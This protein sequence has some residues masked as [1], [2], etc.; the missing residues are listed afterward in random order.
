MSCRQGEEALSARGAVMKQVRRFVRA[1]ALAD[2]VQL[3]PPHVSKVAAVAA[4]CPT[5]GMH[6]RTGIPMKNI[7]SRGMHLEVMQ[8]AQV[9]KAVHAEVAL[10]A[11]ASHAMSCSSLAS[12]IRL[13]KNLIACLHSWHPTCSTFV[14]AQGGARWC[15]AGQWH[16]GKELPQVTLASRMV[17]ATRALLNEVDLVAF[18]EAH[19][20]AAV[21]STT[22]QQ[23]LFETMELMARTDVFLGMHGASPVL[24]SAIDAPNAGF[25]PKPEL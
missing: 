25:S 12:C 15:C 10:S 23:S 20:E 5:G 21:V 7:G 6:H 17:P 18:V 11:S 2:Y 14:R 13:R 4:A 24:G 3:L 1:S 16:S 9:H 22:F 8:L 19:W